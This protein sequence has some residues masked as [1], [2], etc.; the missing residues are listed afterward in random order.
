MNP[1]GELRA[2]QHRGGEPPWV[3]V[4]CL[5]PAPQPWVAIAAHEG[6]RPSGR[7]TGLSHG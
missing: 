5:N 4:R 1:T 3:A 2:L 7:E 6:H